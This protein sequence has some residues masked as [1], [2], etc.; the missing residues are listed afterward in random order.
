MAFD[1]RAMLKAAKNGDQVSLQ[2]LL[3][4]N[5]DRLVQYLSPRIAAKYQGLLSPEDVLQDAYIYA[6]ANIGQFD[7]ASPSAFYAWL[8]AIADNR[9][10]DAIKGLRRKKRGGDVVRVGGN[11][12]N[13]N[14]SVIDLLDAISSDGST[15]SRSV[16]KREA[17]QAIRVAIAGLP[18]DY[19]EAIRLQYFEKKSVTEIAAAMNVS[20]GSV[21]G[22]LRRA[23]DKLRDCLGNSSIYFVKR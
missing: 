10:A 20:P 23:K 8:V 22:I 16:S 5:H 1:E 18:A 4:H 6:F 12:K 11:V 3:I 19:R 21:R 7:S 14:G 9:L 13:E 17:E 15:P 2:N